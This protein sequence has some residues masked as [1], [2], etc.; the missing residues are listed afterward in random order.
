M[1]I[2]VTDYATREDLE[3][4]VKQ[5]GVTAI[6]GTLEELARLNLDHSTS[7]HNIPCKASDFTQEE[8]T[9]KPNRGEVFD[10]SLNG[11]KLKKK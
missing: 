5:G 11:Q 8:V 6:T 7:I 1:E 2:K 3:V 4:K 10:S 9:E